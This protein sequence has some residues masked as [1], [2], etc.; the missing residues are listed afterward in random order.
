MLLII[1]IIIK[2]TIKSYL[3]NIYYV[4]GMV[5]SI[6]YVAIYLIFITT[7]WG[8]HHMVTFWGWENWSTE[9]IYPKPQ[10]VAELGLC[11]PLRLTPLMQPS[12]YFPFSQ[13]NKFPKNG[14]SLLSP[15]S[16]RQKQKNK[17]TYKP[18]AKILLKYEVSCWA[19]PWEGIKSPCGEPKS[20]SLQAKTFPGRLRPEIY[21]P[22]KGREAG[23]LE[24]QD[25]TKSYLMF[26]HYFLHNFSN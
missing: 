21:F 8:E 3:L 10:L 16:K 23:S 17:T 11:C 14:A 9:V 2:S 15:P 13:P 25:K 24:I 18:G 26:L 6:L 7:L 19:L 1:T 5:S 12:K 22:R 20:F 4:Q